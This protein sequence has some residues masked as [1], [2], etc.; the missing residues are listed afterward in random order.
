MHRESN[1]FWRFSLQSY[2][3]PS[4]EA[5]CLALQDRWG[6][7]TNLL[8]YCCWLG[9]AGRPLDKRSLRR[10]MAAVARLQADAIQ[11]L[12]GVRRALKPMSKGL[13]AGWAADLRKRIGAVELDLEYLEQFALFQL[14]QSLPPLASRQP[15]RAAAQAS[16]ARYLALLKLPP[17]ALAQQHTGT[18]LDACFPPTAAGREAQ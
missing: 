15:P 6:T 14:A 4:V 1:A 12:R 13:P 9:S 17:A 18:M 8:L 11:P 10:A 7:D 2:R 5:A 16:I 3:L